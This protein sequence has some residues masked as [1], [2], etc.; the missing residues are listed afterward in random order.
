MS[1]NYCE[2]HSTKNLKNRSENGG[3]LRIKNH[4]FFYLADEK[5]I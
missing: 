5:I 2:A 1:Q 3:G 4:D